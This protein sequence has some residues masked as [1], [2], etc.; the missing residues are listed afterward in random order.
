MASRYWGDPPKPIDNKYY[1]GGAELS[2]SHSM[3]LWCYINRSEFEAISGLDRQR[4][5]LYPMESPS[6]RGAMRGTPRTGGLASVHRQYHVILMD[7]TVAAAIWQRCRLG[8]IPHTRPRR[9]QHLRA[10]MVRGRN[11]YHGRRRIRYV[12]AIGGGHPGGPCAG[13][14]RHHFQHHRNKPDSGNSHHRSRADSR[15]GPPIGLHP[16]AEQSGSE[17]PGN[18]RP[19]HADPKSDT[20]PAATPSPSSWRRCLGR[21]ESERRN[22]DGHTDGSVGHCQCPKHLTGLRGRLHAN[23]AGIW[24][25]G[26]RLDHAPANRVTRLATSPEELR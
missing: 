2:M 24:Q 10:G 15:G 4:L 16:D 11:E 21:D 19:G 23:P 8:A 18:E 14:G 1:S 26:H 20:R 13:P 22:I 17:R 12:S 25:P 6:A 5:I 7:P 9:S 3:F